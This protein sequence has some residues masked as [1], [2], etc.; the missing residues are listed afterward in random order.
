[1]G[2]CQ[3]AVDGQ[4]ES[5]VIPVVL[6]TIRREVAVAYREHGGQP[7][8]Y[9]M[10]SYDERGRP[11]ALIRYTENLGFD[12]VYYAYNSMNQ[13]TSLTTA[14][15]F[16]RHTT[17]YG[18]NDNGQLDSV[19]TKLDTV[20]S[21]TLL[22]GT[23]NTWGFQQYAQERPL[24]A[25]ISYVY[26]P[27]GQVDTMFYPLIDVATW[28]HYTPR[29]WLDTLT[30]TNGLVDLFRQELTYDDAGYITK[31]RSRHDGSAELVQYYSNDNIGQLQAWTQ[32]PNQPGRVH[33]SYSYDPVGNRTMLTV[34][35]G[36]PGSPIAESRASTIGPTPGAPNAGPNQLTTL[37]TLDANS[38]TT[39]S[40]AFVYDTDG[41][42]TSRTM[43]DPLGTPML[44]ERY[45]Y[46][47]WRG[48]TT[49]YERED[50]M[51]PPGGP[52]MIWKWGYRYNAMGEREQKRE[53]QNPGG[54]QG[55]RWTYYLL[56]GT[57]EQLSVWEGAEDATGNACTWISGNVAYL[58]PT[59]YLICGVEYPGIRE[60]IPRL[61]MDIDGTVSYKV[62]DHLASVRQTLDN[63]RRNPSPLRIQL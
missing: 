21:G 40:T 53:L 32:S 28:Y 48:L 37:T 30:A 4:V 10:M 29:K 25:H 15:P 54:S 2:A 13:I 55:F 43:T 26:T 58:A 60:D 57:K 63:H 16:R 9:T 49:T 23:T 45:I 34:Q 46:S 22:N 27:T 5:G 8:H 20:G 19:W 36:P 38:N 39:G 7:Y 44:A 47:S 61:T 31:Q 33:E 52:A 42:M 11:E 1:M 14:D 35:P 3:I 62:T 56:N 24:D 12:A 6:S 51:A 18:Y 59:E 50:L 17:W 41:S